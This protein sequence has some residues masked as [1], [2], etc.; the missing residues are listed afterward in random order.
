M[1]SDEECSKCGALKLPFDLTCD[2]CN[3]FS[4][5]PKTEA[6]EKVRCLLS[7]LD[8]RYTTE[9]VTS[10]Y[11]INGHL[12][13]EVVIIRATRDDEVAI[14]ELLEEEGLVHVHDF[15]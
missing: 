10:R 13:Y 4:V 1:I 7:S 3:E 15:L 12:D 5:R 14:M 8:L 2:S 9:L 6:A 11:S